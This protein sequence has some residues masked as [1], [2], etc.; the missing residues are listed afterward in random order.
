MVV[1]IDM[2]V[3]EQAL[4]TAALSV[5][6]SVVL[7]LW[8]AWLLVNRRFPGSRALG[9]AATAALA[10]PAPVI[11]DY[12]FF[13]PAVAWTWGLAV[14]AALSATPMLVRAGRMAFASLDPV[15]ANTARSLGGSNWRV[16]W[17]VELPQV[18]RPAA[19]A[20][21]ACAR[22]LAELLVGIGIAVR[23]G[24]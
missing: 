15:F 12:A 7:G 18:W 11:C 10:L 13:R 5:A 19:A 3:L 24:R 9:A 6:F 2:P 8:L 1:S 14:A 17:R 21:V 23:L 4:R 16:F 22:V 20:A